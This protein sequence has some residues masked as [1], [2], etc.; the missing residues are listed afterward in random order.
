[1]SIHIRRRLELHLWSKSLP[2]TV[3]SVEMHT[4]VERPLLPLH[5]RQSCGLG[6]TAAVILIAVISAWFRNK[7]D[8][9]LPDPTSMTKIVI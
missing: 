4:G 9:L 1:M 6:V 3:L 7:W 8:D 2:K 5:D